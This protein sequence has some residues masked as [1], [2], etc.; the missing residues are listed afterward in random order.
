MVK[1]G[2][3]VGSALSNFSKLISIMVPTIWKA[4]YSEWVSHSS[5]PFQHLL[6]VFLVTLTILIGVRGNLKADLIWIFLCANNDTHFLRYFLAIIIIFPSFENSLLGPR[7]IFWMFSFFKFLIPWFWTLYMFWILITCQIPS[8]QRF[9]AFVWMLSLLVGC[10]FCS[11]E[12]FGFVKSQ[13][14]VGLNFG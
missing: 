13:S 6:S 2:H 11:A 9:S 14:I 5:H 7:L 12:V 1:L 10:F 8:W 4:T 3:R